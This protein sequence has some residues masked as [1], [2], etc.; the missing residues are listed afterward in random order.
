MVA[1]SRRNFLTT[2][3]L[4]AAATALAPRTLYASS[5]PLIGVQLFSAREALAKDF[6]GTL[7]RIAK[8]G[9]REVEAAGFYDHSAADVKRMMANAG[10]RCVS[11]HYSLADLLKSTDATIEYAKTLGLQYVICSAPWAA[12]P[13]HLEK[14]PGGAWEGILHAMTLDDWKWNAGQFNRIGRKMRQHGLNFG[15]HNHT[16]EFRQE[17]G[18]TGYEALLEGTDPHYVTLELDCG[19]AIAAGQD[20]AKL[21]RSHPGRFSMLHLKDLTPA[22]SGT[23]PDKRVST[24]IGYGVVDFHKILEAAKAVGIKHYFVEQ[25]DF[26][27]PV[28]EALRIDYKSSNILAR[29]GSLHKPRA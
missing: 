27:K 29:G 7:K 12:D 26:D 18:S 10:L 15:Y 25:E 20:T 21:L 19:W 6:P 11:A 3:A 14:Y 17:G 5:A 28:F 8:I 9:Y 16:M 24:E 23:E 13:T 2:G 22:P 1:V 4:A